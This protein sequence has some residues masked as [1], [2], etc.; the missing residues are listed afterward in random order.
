MTRAAAGDTQALIAVGGGL[1]AVGQSVRIGDGSAAEYR[2]ITVVH[3]GGGRH[4]RFPRRDRTPL[5]HDHA[6]G[7]A[8][9]AFTS[10]P[11]TL[12]LPNPVI[13]AD[14]IIT[15]VSPVTDLTTVVGGVQRLCIVRRRRHDDR[16]R[17]RGG[18]RRRR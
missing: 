14:A 3:P 9:A 18:S 10:L 13:P 16:H 1:P 5:A 7:A 11:A 4:Q 2:P 15:V 12:S 8:V 6:A 17:H